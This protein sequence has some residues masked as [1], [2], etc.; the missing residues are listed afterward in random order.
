[1]EARLHHKLAE[2]GEGMLKE[3]LDLR[4]GHKDPEDTMEGALA[5]LR[6]IGI[7]PI[8]DSPEEA[9][10]CIRLFQRRFGLTEDGTLNDETRARLRNLG[11]T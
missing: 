5:R 9:A 10:A 7:E 6:L 2:V 8:D 1:M 3:A 4:L 11:E